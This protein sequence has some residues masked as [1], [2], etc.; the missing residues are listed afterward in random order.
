LFIVQPGIYWGASRPK[1]R[2]VPDSVLTKHTAEFESAWS[3]YSERDRSAHGRDNLIP[4]VSVPITLFTGIRIAQARGKPETAGVWTNAP[5]RFDFD[6]HAK[7]GRHEWI[8]GGGNDHAWTWPAA[9]APDLWS[10]PHAGDKALLKQLDDE[11]AELSE[12]PDPVDLSI[13][14]A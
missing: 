11:K 1:M 9:G 13:P 6:W 12:Q 10:C 2:G 5:R 3:A 14:W 4:T 7:R 8:T